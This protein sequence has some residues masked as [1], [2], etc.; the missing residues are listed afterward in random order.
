MVLVEAR[1]AEAV[2]AKQYD[3]LKFLGAE[4]NLI[5][6]T[7][8]RIEQCLAQHKTSVGDRKGTGVYCVCANVLVSQVDTLRSLAYICM[9][10]ALAQF[11]VFL[12]ALRLLG[13]DMSKVVGDSGGSSKRSIAKT[14]V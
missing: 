9:A 1:V 11:V 14:I 6:G 3:R 13:V 5:D 12:M 4:L 7:K 10:V 2:A 8:A